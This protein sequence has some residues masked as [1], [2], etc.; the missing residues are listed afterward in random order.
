MRN[1][2][3][4]NIVAAAVVVLCCLGFV[5]ESFAQSG[6]GLILRPWGDK[7]S[8]EAST[9]VTVY[10]TAETKGFVKD[11][12]DIWTVDSAGRVR[13]SQ[14]RGALSVGYDLNYMGI[15]DNGAFLGTPVLPDR[16]VDVSFGVGMGVGKIGDWELAANAGVGSASEDPFGD[17]Q[18]I[19]AIANLIATY[20]IDDNMSWQITLNYN[21]NR[22]FLP[23]IPL[24]AVT[25]NH[26]V[27][28]RL[29]Y[30]AGIPY[31][32]ITWKPFRPLTLNVHFVLPV[33][34]SA[35]ATVGIF[36]DLDLYASYVN[37]IHAYHSDYIDKQRSRTDRVFFEQQRV[38]LGL[39]WRPCTNG[40]LTAAG[41]YAFGQSFSTGWDSRDLDT[42][43]DLEDA[44]YFRVGFD[45]SF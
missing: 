12:V 6:A 27:N 43:V 7:Q 13:F 34:L 36:D 32:D 40:S 10:D 5:S 17:S 9:D 41:G 44:L 23:D 31:S 16:L 28:D 24:P 21:G 8:V 29:W 30:S 4:N 2:G 33:T 39:N 25:F 20:P 11:D 14:D 35:T 18:G 1:I 19:Y 45:I 26:K 15:D 37:D 22:T 3:F 42:Y 38:E